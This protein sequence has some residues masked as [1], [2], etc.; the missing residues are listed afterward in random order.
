MTTAAAKK[1]TSER[2]AKCRELV[3]DDAFEAQIALHFVEP[4]LGNALNELKL[5][6]LYNCGLLLRRALVRYLALVLCRLLDKPNE[7]GQTGITASISSLLEMA[8][9]ESVLT[10][11][12]VQKFSADFEKIK[13]DARRI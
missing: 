12:Q 13:T 11:S 3:H 9:S 1:V 6:Y 5:A 4:L 2:F 10:E 8:K 7:K